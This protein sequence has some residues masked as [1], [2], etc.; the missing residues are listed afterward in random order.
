VAAALSLIVLLALI[1]IN[2]VQFTALRGR[3]D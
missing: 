1:V 2:V 3:E